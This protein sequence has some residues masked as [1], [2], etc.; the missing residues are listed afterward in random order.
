MNPSAV[1]MMIV[2]VTVLWGGL[3][4]AVLFL[5]ARPEVVEGEWAADPDVAWS[6]PE[7]PAGGEPLHRDT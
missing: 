2:A 4:R 7:R 1:V 5:R 6:D 3:I